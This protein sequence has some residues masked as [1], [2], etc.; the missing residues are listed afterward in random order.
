MRKEVILKGYKHDVFEKFIRDK[1]PDGLDV[2]NWTFEEIK[3]LVKDFKQTHQPT[4][5]VTELM[6][7]TDT[8]ELYSDLNARDLVLEEENKDNEIKFPPV[9]FGQKNLAD[10]TLPEADKSNDEEAETGAYAKPQFTGAGLDDKDD[11][12]MLADLLNR[13]EDYKSDAIQ[14]PE[15]GQKSK[16]DLREDTSVVEEAASD[17][18]RLDSKLVAYD[19]YNSEGSPND[20]IDSR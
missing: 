4:E 11:D 13:I 12:G 16:P 6:A 5:E 20:K 8:L 7:T 15:P 18:A 10:L 3:S 19:A 2:D 1:K 17:K 9:Q 14:V